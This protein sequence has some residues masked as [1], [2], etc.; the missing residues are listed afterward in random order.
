MT[1][2][3][4]GKETVSLFGMM[5]ILTAEQRQR[6][7]T[8]RRKWRAKRGV[9]EKLEKDGDGWV[10]RY[11]RGKKRLAEARLRPGELLFTEFQDPLLR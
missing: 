1:E 4:D 2:S 6:L 10:I 5:Q 7:G 3:K 8:I 11:G 9:K